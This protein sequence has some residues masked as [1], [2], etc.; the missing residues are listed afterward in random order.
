[1]KHMRLGTA[2]GIIALVILF[3]FVLSVPRAR[4]VAEA[5]QIQTEAE[6]PTVSLR[7][8][9]KKG[10]HTITGSIEAQNACMTASAQAS[11]TGDATSTESILV[12]ITM[13][14]DT[15]FCLQVPTRVPFQTTVAAPA[16]LPIVVT[17]NGATASTSAP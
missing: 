7:D 9:F 15:D 11:V 3:G 4:E 10:V 16:R 13:P 2:A 12:A 1:M 17:V 8:T 14:V 5:P 6:V